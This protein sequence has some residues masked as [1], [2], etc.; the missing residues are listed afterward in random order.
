[1]GWFITEPRETVICA[2][3]HRPFEVV[4]PIARDEEGM[5]I[6]IFYSKQ[7][8]NGQRKTYCIDCTNEMGLASLRDAFTKAWDMW[9]HQ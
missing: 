5:D 8:T 1:M 2:R 9:G 4:K 3:C 7:K 6:N